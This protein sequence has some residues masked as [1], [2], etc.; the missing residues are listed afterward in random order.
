MGVST[1]IYAVWGIKTPWNDEISNALD[2]VYDD[3][4]TPNIIMDGMGGKYMIFGTVLYDSGDFRWGMEDGDIYKEID[5]STLPEMEK[6]YKQEWLAKFPQ[7][8][9]IIEQPF[10]LMMFTHFS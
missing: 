8:S 6:T 3:P 1:N 9:N 10:K 2:D 4:D 7:F 5:F